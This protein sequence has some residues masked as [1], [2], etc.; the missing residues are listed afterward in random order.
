VEHID[1]HDAATAARRHI[2]RFERGITPDLADAYD[3]NAVVELP[4]MPGGIRRL[5]GREAIREHFEAAARAPL[6]LS[7]RNL[8]VHTTADPEVVVAEY[9]Y[10]IDTVTVTLANIQVMRIRRGL[11]VESRDYHDHMGLATV[12]RPGARAPSAGTE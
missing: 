8:R 5:V 7:V 1:D 6:Q 11:I 4:F 2:E 9:D 10:G 3:A 12:L